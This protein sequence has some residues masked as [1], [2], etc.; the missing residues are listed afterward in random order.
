[1]FI[2]LLGN[3]WLGYN[4]VIK[5]IGGIPCKKLKVKSE[6]SKAEWSEVA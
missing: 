3:H 2:S 1:M 4:L 5:Q 6:K